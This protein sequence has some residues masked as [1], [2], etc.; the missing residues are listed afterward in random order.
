[1]LT[2]HHQDVCHSQ[3]TLFWV[4]R[5]HRSQFGFADIMM[6]AQMQQFWRPSAWADAVHAYCSS[7]RFNLG[8]PGPWGL[9]S[10]PLLHYDVLLMGFLPLAHALLTD[11]WADWPI[12][13]RLVIICMRGTTALGLVSI[14]ALF[15]ARKGLWLNLLV[16]NPNFSLSMPCMLA[17]ITQLE[18]AAQMV[19]TTLAQ[20]PQ[21]KTAEV[22]LKKAQQICSGSAANITAR[23][24]GAFL[25]ATGMRLAALPMIGGGVDTAQ[26]E[27]L[28]LLKVSEIKR[29]CLFGNGRELILQE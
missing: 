14:A 16:Q 17:H 5:G 24:K 22:H 15:H 13:Q 19:L 26:I 21:D 25:K 27:R 29:P 8:P 23:I 9:P 7:E 18:T 20:E 3:V 2:D 6:A 11:E 1:M 10:H 12:W 28:M 4:L